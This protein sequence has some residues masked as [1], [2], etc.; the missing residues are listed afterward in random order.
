MIFPSEILIELYPEK[1][2]RYTKQYEHT[3]GGCYYQTTEDDSILTS[4]FVSLYTDGH[5]TYLWGGIEHELNVRYK[6]N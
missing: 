4:N 3:K 6:E 5:L 1:W 2:V